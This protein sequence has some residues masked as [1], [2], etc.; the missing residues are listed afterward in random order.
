M[1]DDCLFCRIVRREIPTPLIYESEDCVAFRDINPQAPT[2]ALVVP[3]KHVVS[4]NEADDPRLL[5]QL[6]LAAAEIARQEGIAESGY[7]TVI[8]TNRNAGQAVFHIHV[9]VIGGRPL[10][11]PPG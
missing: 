6:L 1:A 9:H 3:R 7:R 4:L 8:N 11:W 5:G 2:H 10:G